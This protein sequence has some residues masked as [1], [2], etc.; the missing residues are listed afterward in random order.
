MDTIYPKKNSPFN[1]NTERFE[2]KLEEEKHSKVNPGKLLKRI[3]SFI[4]GP[5]K[6]NHGSHF[7]LN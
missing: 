4:L 3:N 2:S 7:D 6:Y 5:G 1:S